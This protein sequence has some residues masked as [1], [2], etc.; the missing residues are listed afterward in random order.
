[1]KRLDVSNNIYLFIAGL[2]EEGAGWQKIC[3]TKL[4]TTLVTWITKIQPELNKIW[5]A[6][7]KQG[8]FE[9]FCSNLMVFHSFFNFGWILATVRRLCP[10]VFESYKSNTLQVLKRA[11]N[12]VKETGKKISIYLS[13][14]IFLEFTND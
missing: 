5:K 2:Q 3:K 12:R 10:V 13:L 11:K 7:R 9:H 4:K 8:F 14:E 1:M 6:S